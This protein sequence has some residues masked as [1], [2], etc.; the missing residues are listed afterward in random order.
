MKNQLYPFFTCFGD[1]MKNI[2]TLLVTSII[3]LFTVFNAEAGT[4]VIVEVEV[5]EGDSVKKSNE[6]ITFDESR[7]RIDFPEAGTE[8]TD[9][10]PY[11][12]TVMAVKT[13]L[14]ATN[15]KIRFTALR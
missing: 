9:Q 2:K 1:H 8:V 10:S 7:F 15:Q 14:L 4:R 5:I 11:I 12:M 3:C 6:T 13:G